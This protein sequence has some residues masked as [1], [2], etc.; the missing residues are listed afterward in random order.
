[1]KVKRVLFIG[2]GMLGLVLVYLLQTKLDFYSLLFQ[3]SAPQNVDYINM[4]EIPTVPFV[5]N[6]V[7]R[8]L[9][10][11]L[12]SIAIIYGLFFEKK[13][14][15]FAMFVMFFGLFV[16]V[17]A[18]LILFLSQPAGFSSMLSHLHRV[19]MN[20][21]LMMLLIPAFFYQRKMQAAQSS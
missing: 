6:K 18:Y 5:V 12:F 4:Q 14:A 10:N 15:R 21:V 20:P 13:Y 9:L 19:V 16:L 7:L 3:F 8:Y 1:M 11:D 17:P 2:G